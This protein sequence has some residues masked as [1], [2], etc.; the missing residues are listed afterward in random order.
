MKL[1][2]IKALSQMGAFDNDTLEFE[3]VGR[4]PM[5]QPS[6]IQGILSNFNQTAN[7]YPLGSV[8][9]LVNRNVDKVKMDVELVIRGGMTPMVAVDSSTPIYGA[10]ARAQREFEAVE[11][12]EKVRLVES[13]LYN[14]RKIGTESDLMDARTL[15]RI[16]YAPIEERLQNRLEYMRRSVLFYNNIKS[17]VHNGPD[18]ELTYKHPAYL[19]PTLTGNDRWN[20]YTTSDPVGDLQY[21]A[22]DYVLHT[23]FQI[24]KCVLPLGM[25]RHLSQNSKFREIAV[26]SYQAFNGGREAIASNI[27]DLT[28]IGTL[29]EWDATLSF[30][31]ELRANAASG[32]KVIALKNV[33]QLEV[34]DKITINKLATDERE[35]GTVASISGTSVTL[36]DD[37]VLSLNAGDMVR[38]AKMTIPSDRILILGTQRGGLTNIGAESGPDAEFLNNWAEV[39]STLSRRENFDQPKSGIFSVLRDRMTDDPPSIEQL[40]GI[41]A[42]VNVHYHEA[43]MSPKVL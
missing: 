30:T 36:V 41:R 20:Q 42:L 32:Q 22:E 4:H 37:L 34:G 33:D 9:P 3:E 15:L 17:A 26:N 35:R 25:F 39:T 10:H 8:M 1:K 29:E 31:V 5:L 24:E 19:R 6:Q 14:F 16:K 27:N 28:G 13:D 2:T 7:R 12:R 21:W 40:L 38:Y 18:F 23:G 11:F 43:W